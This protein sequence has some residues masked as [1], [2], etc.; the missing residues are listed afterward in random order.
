MGM[1]TERAVP[2]AERRRILAVDYGEKRMGLALSDELRMTARPLA[3]LARRG[4]RQDL[5]RLRELAREHA[6]G[7]ILVGHPLHMDGTA[8]TMA[9]AAARFAARLAQELGLPVELADE[10][11]SSWEAARTLRESGARRRRPAKAD[12]VAAAVILRE[13]LEKQSPRKE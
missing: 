4:L 8:G 1:K 13:Y 6:V 11:L 7:L 9:A 3:T 5:R 2:L 10:R 12:E